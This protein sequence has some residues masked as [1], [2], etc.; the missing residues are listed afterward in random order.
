[1]PD[2]QTVY[3]S[4]GGDSY[5]GWTIQA[6]GTWMKLNYGRP[7][8]KASL[9]DSD[10]I[11]DTAPSSGKKAEGDQ[12]Y[13]TI[14]ANATSVSDSNVEPS[15]EEWDT[16][17]GGGSTGADPFGGEDV[18]YQKSAGTWGKY[19]WSPE[20][21]KFT[22]HGIVEKEDIPS[23]AITYHTQEE[24]TKGT[25]ARTSGGETT[26]GGQ[27]DWGAANISK[28][29]FLNADGSQKTLEEVY[30]LLDPKLPGI[31]GG[32]LRQ[33]IKDMAPKYQGVAEEEKGFAR[34]AMKKDV[35]GLS[36]E[37]RGA[38]AQMRDAYAG[39]MGTGM[40]GAVTAGEDIAKGFE[41]AQQGYQKSM[42]GLEKGAEQA[43]ESD[44]G[45]WLDTSWFEEP[46]EGKEGGYVRKDGSGIGDKYSLGNRFSSNKNGKQDSFSSFLTQL[47]DAGGR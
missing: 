11:V 2:S 47:P 24:W 9:T 37:A 20:Q 13:E 1:M 43:Y 19:K 5:T 32:E 22:S 41:E 23:S 17:I 26:Y 46:A 27:S 42:Y 18:Y 3:V 29:D 10:L 38:G 31:T 34:E 39:G 33:Q 35:Y 15:P 12:S 36:K 4:A 40:R 28:D 7:F 30:A 16:G 45:G 25:G 14:T 6:D 21:N 44:I 8:N